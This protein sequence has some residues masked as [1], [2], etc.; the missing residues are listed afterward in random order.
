MASVY[1]STG[2]IRFSRH[3]VCAAVFGRWTLMEKAHD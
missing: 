3:N 2:I 1:L